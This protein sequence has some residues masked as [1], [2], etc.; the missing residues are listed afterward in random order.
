MSTNQT[1]SE[2]DDQKRDTVLKRMLETPPKPHVDK[3]N[4]PHKKQESNANGKRD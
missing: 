3:E 1:P 4:P 2:S